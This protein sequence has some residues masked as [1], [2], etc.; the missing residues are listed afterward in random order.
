MSEENDR[1]KPKSG[2]GDGPAEDKTNNSTVSTLTSPTAFGRRRTN[3]DK[4]RFDDDVITDIAEIPDLDSDSNQQNLTEEDL[5]RVI[6]DAPHVRANHIQSLQELEREAGFQIQ[7]DDGLDLSLLTSVLLSRDQVSEHDWTWDWDTLFSELAT[8]LQP[9]G[10]IDDEEESSLSS[11]F[12]AKKIP[13]TTLQRAGAT[14][15]RNVTLADSS[16]IE[17]KKINEEKEPMPS[18]NNLASI[19][20]GRRGIS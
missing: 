1:A 10:Q 13:E 14:G 2:W 4:Q 7:S 9:D 17:I 5:T 15:R 20:Y 16:S 6:A 3:M 19:G 18:N 12:L 8:S 11:D